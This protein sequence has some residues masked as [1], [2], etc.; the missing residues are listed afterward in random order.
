MISNMQRSFQQ[1]DQQH[2]TPA[3]R[4]IDDLYAPVQKQT[5]LREFFEKRR[6]YGNIEP[7]PLA[8]PS[9]LPPMPGAVRACAAVVPHLSTRV[10]HAIRT[11][12]R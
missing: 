10:S 3:R 7:P 12:S 11:G 9:H 4:T 1:Q 2:A 5:S 6:L 8:K